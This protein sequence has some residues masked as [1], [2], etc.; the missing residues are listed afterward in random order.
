MHSQSYIKSQ[1]AL[2][3]NGTSAITRSSTGMLCI[4]LELCWLECAR[5]CWRLDANAHFLDCQEPRSIVRRSFHH[6]LVRRCCWSL[7]LDVLALPKATTDSQ[8][9]LL[10]FVLFQCL[11]CLHRVAWMV[12]LPPSKSCSE[13][14]QRIAVAIDTSRGQV[15]ELLLGISPHA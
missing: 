2:P 10:R 1:A 3:I 11:R 13:P 15:A 4:N 12:T 6:A 7:L 5:D 14:G 9:R 8:A